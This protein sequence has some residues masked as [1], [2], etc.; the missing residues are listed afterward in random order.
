MTLAEAGSLVL[1]REPT[2]VGALLNDVAAGYRWSEKL[3]VAMALSAF[4]SEGTADGTAKLRDLAADPHVN[5]SY[6]KDRT[7]E[8]V[9]VAGLAPEEAT[10]YAGELLAPY[11]TAAPRRATLTC[12]ASP[13]S[14]AAP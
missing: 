6:Y 8:W 2:H 4:D 1:H 13:E 9:S 11:P 12:A 3:T 10:Q 5:L 7:R 14:P